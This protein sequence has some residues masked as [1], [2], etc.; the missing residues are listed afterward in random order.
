[1]KTGITGLT[2]FPLN[3]HNSETDLRMIEVKPLQCMKCGGLGTEVNPNS[4]TLSRI[5]SILNRLVV[6]ALI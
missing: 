2:G 6:P 1:M 5:R 3:Q 4:F